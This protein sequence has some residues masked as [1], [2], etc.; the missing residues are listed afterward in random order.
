[1]SKQADLQAAIA[2]LIDLDAELDERST[3][4]PHANSAARADMLYQLRHARRLAAALERQVCD[5]S[6]T[7]RL[8]GREEPIDLRGVRAWTEAVEAR[9]AHVCGDRIAVAA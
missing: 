8:D 1:V 6:C 2:Y 4:T 9:I 7:S 5:I 3:A